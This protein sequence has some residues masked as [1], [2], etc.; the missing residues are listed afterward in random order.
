[1]TRTEKVHDYFRGASELSKYLD[2]VALLLDAGAA[3]AALL[4][5]FSA[6]KWHWL[7]FTTLLLA[8]LGVVLRAYASEARGFAQQCRKISLRAFS[9]GHD[10]DV[11]TTSDLEVSSFALGNVIGGLLPAKG[12]DEYYE[13]TK[14]V[15]YERLRELCAH[16][17]FYTWR[18]MNVYAVVLVVLGAVAFGACWALLY[19]LAADA[20]KPA[21]ERITILEALCS[22]L[23]VIFTVRLLENAWHAWCAASGAKVIENALLAEGNTTESVVNLAHAY[24]IER[25]ASLDPPTA[26]YLMMQD[27]LK[28][29]WHSRRETLTTIPLP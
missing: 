12:L 13:P 2:C 28:T 3:V 22:V 4:A 25:A 29:Q 8:V 20:T 1:M 9:M 26:I 18:I 15:G 5:L 10:V 24:D 27:G 17:A 14:P 19:W 16:S 21:G 6:D 11:R 23:F 7:P